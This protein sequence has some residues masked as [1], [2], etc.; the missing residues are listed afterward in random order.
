MI[1][2]L[3][4][5]LNL[6]EEEEGD[7]TSINSDELNDILHTTSIKQ[8]QEDLKENVPVPKLSEASVKNSQGI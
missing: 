4:K 5:Y 2:E 6:N 7:T 8:G 3:S 1:D